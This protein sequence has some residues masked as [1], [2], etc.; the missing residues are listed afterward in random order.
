MTTYR[1]EILEVAEGCYRVSEADGPS[2]P[3]TGEYPTLDEAMGAVRK[4]AG[5]EIDFE[6]DRVSLDGETQAAVWTAEWQAAR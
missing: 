6:S 5:R 2:A 4:H 1:Y 3:A